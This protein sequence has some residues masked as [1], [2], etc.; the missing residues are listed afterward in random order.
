MSSNPKVQIISGSIVLF[1]DG[2]TIVFKAPPGLVG[3]ALK[4]Y[5]DDLSIRFNN[6]VT[7]NMH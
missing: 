7:A 3:D 1:K 2:A 5:A 4:N 6:F